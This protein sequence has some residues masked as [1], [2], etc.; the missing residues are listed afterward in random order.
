M[1]FTEWFEN[2]YN[3]KWEKDYAYMYGLAEKAACE[4][5]QYCKMHSTIPI[6]NG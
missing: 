2:V 4:Y 3:E 1:S 5:E 6:W